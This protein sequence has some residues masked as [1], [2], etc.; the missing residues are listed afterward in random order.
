MNG[1]FDRTTTHAAGIGT[2]ALLNVVLGIWFFVSPWVF[3]A[4]GDPNAW[5]AWIVGA[6]IALIGVARTTNPATLRLFAWANVVLGAWVFFS[7][8]ILGY[9]G[10][11]GWYAN[12]LCVGA[13]IFLL[14]IWTLTSQ[15]RMAM[16]HPR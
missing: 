13:L 10:N 15:P 7:P 11:T 12:S 14:S 4:A 8:W 3:G 16:P 2:A 1:E 5:N 9:G 6:L